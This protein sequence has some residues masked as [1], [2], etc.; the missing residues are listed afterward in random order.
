[1]KK[2]IV[3]IALL[4]AVAQGA[5]AEDGDWFTAATTEGVAMTFLVTSEEDKTCEVSKTE[6]GA[7]SV[8]ESTAGTVTIPAEAN[9]YA[10]TSVGL[11]A[12]KDCSGLTAIT[13]PESVTNIDPW[14]FWNCTGLTTMTIPQSV[15]SIGECAFYGCSGL[16]SITVD[17]GNAT[18]D[19]RNGCNAVIETETGTLV[20]GSNVSTV[21]DGVTAIGENAFIGCAGLT[22]VTLPTSVESIG[23]FAF[24]DCTA[25]ATLTLN[26]GLTTI[27]DNAFTGCTALTSISIPQS[28]TKISSNSFLSCYGI[29]RITVAEGNTKY[30]S[31][32]GCDAII[33]ASKSKVTLLL[34]CK[35]TV[36][37]SSVTT[38]GKYAFAY[39]YG[40]TSMTIPEGVTTRIVILV[41]LSCFLLCKP[42]CYFKA[43]A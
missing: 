10:V 7:P 34:G 28:V 26:E 22:A 35:N 31:R 15:D 36:I 23:E 42:L 17:E 14:A 9:G 38:I 6:D 41:S 20:L 21:P 24:Q 19:S 37:P 16:V 29:E 5:W 12:F 30:D 27:S 39:C 2:T 11:M 4:C 8:D 25:L 3:I 13:M 1:M 32:N 40:L 18:Y 33:E 43:I